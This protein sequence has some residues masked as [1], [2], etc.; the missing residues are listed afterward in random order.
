VTPPL[1]ASLRLDATEPALLL[2]D[3]HFGDG[4]RTDL[5][6]G[7]DGALIDF[8]ERWRARLDTFV[9]LG[10]ILDMP[11]AWRVRR[12]R[13]AHAELL[14]CL[15][16]LAR[17]ARVVF[18]RGNHDASV[19]YQ[20]LFPGARCCDSVLLGDR[21]LAWHGHQLDLVMHPGA[22]DAT[23]KTYAHAMLERLAGCR[24]IPPLERYDSP[25]N[26]LAL[27]IAIHAARVTSLRARASRAVG[28]ERVAAALEDRVRYLARS[29]I[30]D[31]ADIFGA[32]DRRM[33]GER[34]DT[35]VCGHSHVPGIARTP[36]GIYVNTGSWTCGWQTYALW[37]DDH[38]L[39][40]DARDEREIGDG[41]LADVPTDTEPEDLFRWWRR[42]HKGLLRFE[43]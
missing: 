41:E 1:G 26:R 3:L 27:T 34:F 20:A 21:I 37:S 19:D 2:S 11:Q 9:L 22:R 31:P 5:I 32:T 43:L 7:Q 35:V 12:I 36:R 28:R 16:R 10:D 23:I 15:A 17:S 40:F 42:H 33:L 29:V 8:L 6:A 18:V 4:G 30:G 39:L 38:F 13:S 24:L 14:D 25:A